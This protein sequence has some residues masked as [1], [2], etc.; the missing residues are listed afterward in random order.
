MTSRLHISR[1]FSV[2]QYSYKTSHSLGVAYN[3]IKRLEII[4]NEYY[5][6]IREKMPWTPSMQPMKRNV[7]YWAQGSSLGDPEPLH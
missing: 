2:L 1:F 5:V 3:T 6:Y 7:I 4:G